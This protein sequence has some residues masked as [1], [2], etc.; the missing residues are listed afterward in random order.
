MNP[1]DHGRHAL[2]SVLSSIRTYYASA[3]LETINPETLK[4]KSSPKA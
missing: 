2:T 1:Y 3:S 4:P